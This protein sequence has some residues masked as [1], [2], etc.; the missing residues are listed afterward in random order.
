MPS[1][2][3]NAGN[4]VDIAANYLKAKPSTQFGTRQLTVIKVAVANLTD[5]GGADYL[6]S[7]SLFSKTVRALQQTAEV[8]AVFTPVSDTTD[9]FHAIIATDTQYVGDSETS[10]NAIPSGGLQPAA[11]FGIFETAI[12]AGNGGVTATVTIPSDFVAPFHG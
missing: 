2:I 5:G 4:I 10:R 8:W 11:N 3:A 7:D 12:A 6:L 1:Q 9:Y